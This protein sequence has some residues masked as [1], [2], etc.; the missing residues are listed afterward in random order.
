[1]TKYKIDFR[2]IFTKE[3]YE[4]YYKPIDTEFSSKSFEELFKELARE[5]NDPSKR[6]DLMQT[7]NRATLLQMEMTRRLINELHNST[8]STNRLSVILIALTVILVF[9]TIAL[10]ALP[11]LTGLR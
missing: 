8:Q 4:E 3:A 9:L 7:I 2:N 11:F 1:M 5:I 6:V 10:I